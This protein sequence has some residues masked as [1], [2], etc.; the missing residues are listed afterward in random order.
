MIWLS[1]TMSRI[2]GLA[3]STITRAC[4]HPIRPDA[5]AVGDQREPPAQLHG[6]VHPSL[7]DRRGQ[8]RLACQ[9]PR[10]SQT[11]LAITG[12][13]RLELG[14]HHGLLGVEKR[15]APLERGRSGDKVRIG[16]RRRIEHIIAICFD[17]PPALEHVFDTNGAGHPAQL[18]TCDVA[19]GAGGGAAR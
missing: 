3:T 19:H 1:A 6:H 15:P 9:P 11:E 12:V 7:G 8:A 4:S 13:A 2:R 5:N 10:R 16:E 14:Q 17:L 18:P